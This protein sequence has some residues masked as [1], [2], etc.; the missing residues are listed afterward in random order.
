MWYRRD[1]MKAYQSRI[2]QQDRLATRYL[3]IGQSTQSPYY[4]MDK[5]YIANLHKNFEK[6]EVIQ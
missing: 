2:Q 1:A 6:G 3:K 4:K 5:D